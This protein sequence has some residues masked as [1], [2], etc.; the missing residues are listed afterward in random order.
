[1]AHLTVF[2]CLRSAHVCGWDWMCANV[3]ESRR[4]CLWVA[5]PANGW[6]CF[7]FTRSWHDLSHPKP[8]K[9][10][11]RMQLR[12]TRILLFCSVIGLWR[13]LESF[14]IP[15]SAWLSPLPRSWSLPWLKRVLIEGYRHDRQSSLSSQY[16]HPFISSTSNKNLSACVPVIAYHCLQSV[17]IPTD[18]VCST[19]T[20]I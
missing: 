7:Y 11:I 17:S 2:F 9:C 3:T 19:G 1:M 13:H 18:V 16:N 6:C 10:S 5:V 4:C 20:L 14:V 8:W 12:E 15:S